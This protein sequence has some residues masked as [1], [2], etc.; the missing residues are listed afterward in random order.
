MTSECKNCGA[1]LVGPYCS[2]CGQRADVH[3]A[4]LGALVGDALGD[5]YNLD[6]RLWRSLLTLASKPGRMTS[7][8]LEGQRAKYSPPFR[9]YVVSSVAFFVIFSLFRMGLPAELLAGVENDQAPAGTTGASGAAA[10]VAKEVSASAPSDDASVHLT[11]DEHGWSCNLGAGPNGAFRERLEAACRKIES[12][13]GA[14]FVRAFVDHVPVMMLL[15]IPIIA[16]LMKALYLFSGRKYVEHVVFFLHTH[17]FFFVTAIATVLLGS[18]ASLLPALEGPARILRSAAWI[19][20]PVYFYL[21]MRH[22][23]RQGYALTTVKYL[24]L[25]GGYAVCMVATLI[26]LVIYTAVTL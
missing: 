6:S 3:I 12:D 5:L 25:G 2:E 21:A 1:T 10:R 7:R 26:G 15:F 17:S 11:V 14:S 20:F 23:Y 18:A 8:Y 4:S 22:V 13:N 24:L 16:V 19:Y 9:M